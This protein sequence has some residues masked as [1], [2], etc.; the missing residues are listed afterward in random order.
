[1]KAYFILI[2][3]L[4]CVSCHAGKEKTENNNNRFPNYENK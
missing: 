1:M 4:E 3:F 2:C